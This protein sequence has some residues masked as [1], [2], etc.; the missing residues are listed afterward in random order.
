MPAQFRNNELWPEFLLVLFVVRFWCGFFCLFVFVCL[1]VF[2][3]T[4]Q[5]VLAVGL[6][7]IKTLAVTILSTA[8]AE[9]QP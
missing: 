6:K 3:E 4:L 7:V 1:F 2:K 9:F 5:L 8:V